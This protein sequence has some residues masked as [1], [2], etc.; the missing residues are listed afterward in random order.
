[1]NDP[2]PTWKREIDF[3]RWIASLLGLSEGDV[4]YIIDACYSCSIAVNNPRETLAASAIEMMSDARAKGLQSFAQAF[5]QTIRADPSPATV[6]QIHARLLSQWQDESKGNHLQ[7]TPVHKAAASFDKPSIILAPLNI[8]PAT[9]KP[10]QSD[11]A[12]VL[13]TVKLDDRVPLNLAEW[14]NWLQRQ[15]PTSVAEIEVEGVFKGNSKVVL[16]RLPVAIWDMLPD[17]DAYIFVDYVQSSNLVVKELETTV[18]ELKTVR[19]AVP[20]SSFP[21]P[22]IPPDPEQKA[23]FPSIAEWP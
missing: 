11:T 14:R 8:L 15:I 7:T 17:H 13:I 12:K 23:T 6:A 22:I 4:L 1:M 3:H 5:C 16:L 20:T 2:D 10:D 18:K 9:L 19:S 21:L